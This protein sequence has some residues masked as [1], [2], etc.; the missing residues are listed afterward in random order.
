VPGRRVLQ[1]R[2]FVRGEPLFGEPDMRLEAQAVLFEF[3]VKG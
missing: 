2:D 1:N 3:L